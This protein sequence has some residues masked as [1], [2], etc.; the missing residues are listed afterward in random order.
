MNKQIFVIDDAEDILAL[1]RAAL[2][3]E[4]Y[5]VYTSTYFNQILSEIEQ[6]HPDL[7]ILDFKIGEQYDGW[8]ALQSLRMNRPTA[9]IPILLCTGAVAEVREQEAYLYAKQ[10]PVLYKP[11]DI[12]ELIS[13][14]GQLVAGQTVPLAYYG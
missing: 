12:D 6:V 9:D 14:V 10:I 3:P 13:I 2:E 4:G 5:Q 1:F 8:H 11:F 7:I